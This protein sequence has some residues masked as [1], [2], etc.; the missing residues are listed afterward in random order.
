MKVK[1]LQAL[2]YALPIL[3]KDGLPG[4]PGDEPRE[5]RV[6]GFVN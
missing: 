6:L 3:N 1:V 2:P 5:R 4:P